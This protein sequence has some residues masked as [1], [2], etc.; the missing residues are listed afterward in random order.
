M[1]RP[2][3]PCESLIAWEQDYRACYN[4]HTGIA[5][6]IHYQDKCENDAKCKW[7]AAAE[8]CF[9]ADKPAPCDA[10]FRNFSCVKD[11]RCEW[12]ELGMVCIR[13]G[14]SPCNGG[15]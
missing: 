15:R 4:K 13:K 3:Y 10:Y 5:C 8:R 6:H 12:S 7:N 2:D 9:S 11:E 14:S 1:F